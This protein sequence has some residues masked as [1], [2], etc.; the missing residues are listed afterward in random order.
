[1]SPIVLRLIMLRLVMLRLVMLRVTTLSYADFCADWLA[2]DHKLDHFIGYHLF[3]P[4]TQ[5]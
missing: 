3:F 1:M 2:L 4:M 5:K